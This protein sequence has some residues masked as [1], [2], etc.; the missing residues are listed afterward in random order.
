M[1]ARH[2]ELLASDYWRE[3][4]RDVI[5]PL[6]FG[7]ET[8]AGLGEDV[9][10]IGP[11]PGLTT[12]WLGPQVPRLTGLELDPVLSTALATRMAATPNVTIVQGDATAI[13]F[14]DGRFSAAVCFTMLHHVPEVALQ[15]RMLAEVCRVLRPGGLFMAS[16]SIR[17]ER[18]AGLHEDDIY[19]PVDPEALPARLERAGFAEIDVRDDTLTWVVHARSAQ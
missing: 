8:P 18:L 7:K 16:D 12:D 3:R 9:L 11:G 19:N 15:D 4:L 6:A 5:L 14:D 17:S 13:P 1:N 10:E 2:L